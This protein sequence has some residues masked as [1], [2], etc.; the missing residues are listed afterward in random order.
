[1]DE[2]VT[3]VQAALT[4]DLLSPK[5]RRLRT[6]HPHSGHCY[7]AAEACFHLLGGK[8]AGWTPCVLTHQ[9]WP[10]GLDAGETHWFLRRGSEVCDP[11]AGQ[12]E[13]E[14]RYD[15]GRGSGFLT[16][17]PSRRARQVIRRAE[18]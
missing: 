8:S 10:A 3:R 13:V 11:T 14:I 7:V 6:R 2:V 18:R 9:L 5:W 16:R 15:L 1:M 4:D 17:E 12:F